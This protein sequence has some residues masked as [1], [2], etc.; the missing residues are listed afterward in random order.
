VICRRGL[1]ITVKSIR[2][3]GAGAKGGVWLK[4]FQALASDPD[5]EY[6]MIDSSIVRAHQHSGG[7]KGGMR[8][9]K[10]LVAA[11]AD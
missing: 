6:A 2:A 4:V 10:A 7:A 11:K 3:F 9:R 8:T 1:V 5:N